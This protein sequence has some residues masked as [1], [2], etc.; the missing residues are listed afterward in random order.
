M[1]KKKSKKV[2]TIVLNRNLAIITAIIT[3]IVI[4]I[5]GARSFYSILTKVAP[6]SYN[7]SMNKTLLTVGPLIFIGISIVLLFILLV[8]QNNIED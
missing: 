2:K 6:T 5:I 4:S 1:S 7:A 8:S 3:N